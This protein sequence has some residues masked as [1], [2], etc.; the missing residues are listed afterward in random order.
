MDGGILF[1]LF[2]TLGESGRFVVVLRIKRWRL[3]N[4]GGGNDQ[5]RLRSH[6]K[7]AHTNRNAKWFEDFQPSIFVFICLDRL[8][9]AT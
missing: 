9:E 6:S 1:A 7:L 4:F 8:S 2:E 3:G 5:I